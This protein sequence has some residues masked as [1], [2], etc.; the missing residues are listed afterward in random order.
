MD[1]QMDDPL[2]VTRAVWAYVS[3]NLPGYLLS[4]LVMFGVVML[5]TMGVLVVIA[6]SAVPA[7]V[8]QDSS[9]AQISVVVGVL[10]ATVVSFA[11]T[12]VAAL[13]NAS[14]MRALDAHVAGG[15]P[16]AWNSPFSTLT[17]DAPRVVL[18]FVVNAVLTVAALM[19]CI[20]P[21]IPM[22]ALLSFA[23]PLVVLEGAGT[24]EALQTAGRHMVDNLA[25]HAGVWV[26]LAVVL[27]V[28]GATGIGG[29]V[30]SAV[31]VAHQVFAYRMAWGDGGAGLGQ[32]A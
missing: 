8:M 9:V 19:A 13:M 3:D 20:V 30:G 24:F 10:V 2:A 5:G 28:L 14:L 1:E 32:P 23:M 12:V 16:V 27:M 7:V 4:A 29:L 31:L 22:W 15:E 25:W 11:F 18:F 21:V 26:V 17:Q 6:L